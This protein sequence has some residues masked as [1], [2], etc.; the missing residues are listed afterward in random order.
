VTDDDEAIADAPEEPSSRSPYGLVAAAIVAIAFAGFA[1]GL[2]TRDDAKPMPPPALEG[3]T[4]KTE[5]TATP[6]GD[7]L[8][9]AERLYRL[10]R[11]EA[12]RTELD[13]V[14]A[15]QPGNARAMVLRSN[16]LIEEDKL[17]EALAVAQASVAAAPE[18]ADA[19]LALGVIQQERAELD[20]AAQAYRR[21][22][23]LAPTGAYAETIRRQLARIE[24]KLAS[25]E[26]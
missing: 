24:A 4:A 1:Y 6:L 8:A 14:L 5:S 7:R 20:A 18:L 15:S 2:R 10:G 3:K 22:L 19:H 11:T 9:E 12:A 21:Y 25:Q 23:E 17:D 13:A 16:L 26:G